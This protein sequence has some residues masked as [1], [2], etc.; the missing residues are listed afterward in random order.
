M[1]FTDSDLRALEPREKQYRVATGDGLYVVVYPNGS[2]YFT[3]V[4]RYPP[5]RGGQQR[6]HHI[7]PY[8]KGSG[9]WSLKA[10][11]DER[12]RLDQLRKAG[13][14]PRVLKADAKREVEKKAKVPSLQEVAEDYLNRSRNRSSTVNDYRNMLFNQVL[15]VLGHHSPVNRFEW[16]SG[17]RQKVL[18]LKKGIE[19]RGSLYQ[20]DKCL[21]V[22]R[23]MF[24]HAIDNAWM[25]PPNPALG[26]KGARSK[27]EPKHHPTLEWDQLPQF[28]EDLERNDPKGNFVVVSAVKMLFLTFLRVSSLSGLRWEEIDYKKGLWIIPAERMKAK[29]DHKIPLTTQIKEVLE[30][31]H[32]VTGNEEYAFHTGMTRGKYPHM[33]PS[34]INNHLIRL[35]YKGILTGHGVRAIPLTAG[36]E[37]LNFSPDVIQR[38]MAHAIGDKVR[39]AYDRAQFM[40]ERKKFM[41]AWC[42]ALVEQGLIT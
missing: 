4:Y 29:Q 16:Y 2:K 18:D 36:Q 34:S 24:E 3:W 32:E 6:W 27:H 13:D 33:N 40:K 17:G 10:A 38:Q 23:S 5:G 20:S 35:G 31:L 41:I 7:G 11:R 19:A 22:M 21:M 1:P 25:Q 12:D 8:G 14:D 37:V 42:D 39:Q 28:F 15:P 26:S 9:K 30:K